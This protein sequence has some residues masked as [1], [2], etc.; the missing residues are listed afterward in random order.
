M[1]LK[2]RRGLSRLSLLLLM[3]AALCASAQDNAPLAPPVPLLWKVSDADSS[4]YLLGSFHLL[5][6]QD[7]PLSS[8]VDVAFKDAES[9]TFEIAPQ[10]MFSPSFG[11]QMGQAGLRTDGSVLDSELT[12]STRSL[13]SHWVSTHTESLA[14]AGMTSDMLQRFK[15]W[16]VGLTI[17]VV[18]MTEQGLDP[19]LGLDTHLATEAG[20]AGKPTGGL[21][22]AAQQIAFFD[23]MER[24]AQV[25]FLEESL[26]AADEGPEQ[27]RRLHAAWRAGQDDVL[28]NEMGVQMQ[29]EYP[30]LYRR[31]NAERNK[32]WLPKVEQQL[33]APSGN[34]AM[35]VVGALHLLGP[36]GLVELLKAKGYKVERICSV[37]GKPAK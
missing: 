36:D 5:M 1:T 21:E 34:D 31:V 15:P 9:L 16:F 17:S 10:E 14:R 6:P 26:T 18:Q 35:L 19:K 37:C 25:Q 8:D 3:P 30:E 24:G 4:V 7:Y 23:G 28:W 13:L 33:A 20:K 32:A 12:P 27:A 22:T 2:L 11:L 29:Q